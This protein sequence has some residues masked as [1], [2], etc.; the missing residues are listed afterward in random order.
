MKFD[1]SLVRHRREEVG[2]GHID[3]WDPLHVAARDDD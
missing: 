2:S 3:E 1:A